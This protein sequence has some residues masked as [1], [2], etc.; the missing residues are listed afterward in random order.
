MP[1]IA[2]VLKEEIRRIAKSEMRGDLTKLRKDNA[3]LKR[4]L[5]DHKRRLA[6][7][8]K[9]DRQLVADL[10]SRRS[11]TVKPSDDEV[12]KARIT[13]R[14]ILALRKKFGISQAD[15]ARLI[16]VTPVSVFLWEKKGGRLQLRSASV[17]AIVE[18]RKLKVN[19][20]RER[21]DQLKAATPP[22]S[23]RRKRR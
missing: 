12:T 7:V 1:N 19:E 4:T 23:G 8:E 9:N 14:M 18:V 5:A 10:A 16:G 13:G 20:A 15:L 6:A 3:A 21:L 11:V 22:V 2:K 17:A